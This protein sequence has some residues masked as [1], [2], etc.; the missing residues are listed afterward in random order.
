MTI[1]PIP[2][3]EE[4]TPAL[5]VARGSTIAS[6][7]VNRFAATVTAAGCMA[8]TGVA[9]ARAL[10]PSGKGAVST[11]SYLSALLAAV[12][13]L[14]LGDA[15]IVLHGSRQR[16]VRDTARSVIAGTL[17]ASGVAG[18][19]LVGVAQFAHVSTVPLVP[20]VL[21][22]AA[23]VAPTALTMNLMRLNE[24]V[25]RITFASVAYLAFAAA[26]TVLTLLFVSVAGW[27]VDG[28]LVAL[29]LGPLAS[30]VLLLRSLAR[31][32]QLGWRTPAAASA[33][34]RD[35]RRRLARLG[36]PLMGSSVLRSLT[37]RVDLLIVA[38]MAGRSTAG[39]YTVALS[40]SELVLYAPA[41]LAAATFP[42][43][44]KLRDDNEVAALVAELCRSSAVV[45][46]AVAIPAA[47]LVPFA[48]PALFGPGFSGAIGPTELL[49]V[50]TLL[51]SLQWAM[52]RAAAA[53][54]DT[55]PLFRSFVGSTASMVLLDLLLVPAVGATGAAVAAAVG[56]LAGCVICMVQLRAGSIRVT[57]GSL[58]P[59]PADARR[60]VVRLA[61]ERR[62]RL[63]EFARR[64]SNP[65][66]ELRE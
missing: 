29:L 43:L 65:V 28:A 66:I 1:L 34:R 60:L 9:T 38:V 20:A 18:V 22:A 7:S 15:A 27:G 40:V 39:I 21:L 51:L 62:R 30:T 25:G 2:R 59:A 24:A 49:F 23:T 48:I 50:S 52:A 53:R 36:L 8:V 17:L 64:R 55:R 46:V 32:G 47:V 19:V 37:R 63:D 41:A 11:L 31:R 58:V 61:H 12:A 14:G 35:D 45:V 26:T 33:T 54:G 5:E 57:P 3:E 4:E 10:G 13:A 16:P 42:R 6:T 44:A 56:P